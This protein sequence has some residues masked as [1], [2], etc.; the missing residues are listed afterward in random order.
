MKPEN[1]L[2]SKARTVFRRLSILLV[3]IHLLP[4]FAMYAFAAGPVESLESLVDMFVAI[5]KI[6]GVLA[7]LWGVLQLAISF[8]SHDPSQRINGVMF[9]VGGLLIYFADAIL[10]QIG[11]TI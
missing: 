2:E 1:T 7:S 11:V 9:L 8:S 6:A 10:A 4:C 3:F 5:V